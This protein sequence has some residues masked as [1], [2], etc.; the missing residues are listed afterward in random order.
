MCS[1]ARYSLCIVSMF[2]LHLDYKLLKARKL[3]VSFSVFFSTEPTILNA[4]TWLTFGKY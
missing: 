1:T 4:L 2:W 3:T